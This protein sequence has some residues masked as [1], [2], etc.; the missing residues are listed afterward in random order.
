MA[1]SRGQFAAAIAVAVMGVCGA[2]SSRNKNSC[3][4]NSVSVGFAAAPGSFLSWGSDFFHSFYTD[5]PLAGLVFS[6]FLH[7]VII[8]VNCG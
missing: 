8:S 5:I 1:G 6:S 2:G 7:K 4:F 3:L